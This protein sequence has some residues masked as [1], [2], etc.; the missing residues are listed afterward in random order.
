MSL[1]RTYDLVE[2]R[3]EHE[4]LE[5]PAKIEKLLK[6]CY[7]LCICILSQK[8]CAEPWVTVVRD[9]RERKFFLCEKRAAKD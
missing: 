8:G 3:E 1:T 5:M 4:L 2:S 9:R 6:N 7:L